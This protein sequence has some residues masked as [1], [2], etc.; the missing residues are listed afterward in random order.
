MTSAVAI[1]PAAGASSR[2]GSMKLVADVDGEPLLA[3]TLTC[4]FDAGI[5]QVVVVVAADHQLSDV[6][7]LRDLRVTVVIN[8]DPSRGMFSSIQTGLAA[9]D[10]HPIVVLPADMPFVPSEVVAA[11]VAEAERRDA[12]VVPTHAGVKGHPLVV[13]GRCRH[14]LRAAVP[15]STLKD[16]LA[17]ATGSAPIEVP[18]ASRG[19]VRDVD[20]PADLQE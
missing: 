6:S 7:A 18:V 15:T 19:V 8:P 5:T 14:A 11:L 17:A 2:F 20:V 10:G 3:R 12:C 16:A 1:V 4:L 9:V 13:P